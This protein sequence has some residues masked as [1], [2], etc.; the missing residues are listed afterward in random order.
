MNKAGRRRRGS[1]SVYKDFL[2]SKASERGS[3]S[4]RERRGFGANSRIFMGAICISLPCISV[5]RKGTLE[6]VRCIAMHI[7][8]KY[9]DRMLKGSSFVYAAQHST[10]VY[11]AKKVTL[12]V[13]YPAKQKKKKKKKS[14]SSLI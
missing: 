12:A 2:E 4:D 14:T 13:S 9:Y 7:P 6:G 3:F 10:T 1:F 8:T 11:P 5:R